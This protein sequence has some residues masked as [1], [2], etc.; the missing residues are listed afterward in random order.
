[1]SFHFTEAGQLSAGQGPAHTGSAEGSQLRKGTALG[2]GRPAGGWLRPFLRRLRREVEG[3]K[4]LFTPFLPLANWKVTLRWS[5]SPAQR[6]DSD[7][8]PMDLTFTLSTSSPRTPSL[9]P[10]APPPGSSSPPLF[11]VLKSFPLNSLLT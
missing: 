10:W 4:I 7:A 1:M 5:W 8:S 2:S 9:W 11:C 3:E 6:G